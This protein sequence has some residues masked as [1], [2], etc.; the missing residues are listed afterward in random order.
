MGKICEN[1]G[2]PLID[3]KS[4]TY[5]SGWFSGF[6]DTDGS[7]YFNEASGQIFITAVQKNRY[8]L[9]ALVELYGGSIYPMVKQEAFKW[10][11][12]KKKEVLSLVNDYFKVNPCRS[13]KIMRITMVNAITSINESQAA[14]RHST[15]TSCAGSPRTAARNS[16]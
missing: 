3:P 11:C 7:I 12:F 4:L 15:T 13:E 8:I 10:T 1:Y 2:L 6:F 9:E 5:H 16:K 14:S